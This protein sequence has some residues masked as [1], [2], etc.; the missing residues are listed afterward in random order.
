MRYISW[1]IASNCTWKRLSCLV[2]FLL[3]LFLFVFTNA[4]WVSLAVPLCV[5]VEHSNSC[6]V[7]FSV[8]P[9]SHVHKLSQ[10]WIECRLRSHRQKEGKNRDDWAEPGAINMVHFF[11]SF[12]VTYVSQ[13]WEFGLKLKCLQD[14]GW[15][16]IRI[17][18]AIDCFQA[19]EIYVG[20]G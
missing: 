12:L 8:F 6:R 5:C 16:L 18:E 3:L 9:P 15:W 17:E 19:D 4:N 20:A 1:L 11:C 2:F 14:S 10:I 7:A 13:C